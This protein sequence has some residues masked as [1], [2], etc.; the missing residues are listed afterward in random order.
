MHGEN[1]TGEYKDDFQTQ[2]LINQ[3][4]EHKIPQLNNEHADC[5]NIVFK[6]RSF[7]YTNSMNNSD[8]FRF[9]GAN[10]QANQ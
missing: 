4:N 10:C 1:K 8:K 5:L 3:F 6:F 7:M 2:F 9:V